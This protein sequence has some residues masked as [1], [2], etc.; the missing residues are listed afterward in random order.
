MKKELQF[1]EIIS[2]PCVQHRA[3]KRKRKIQPWEIIVPMMF[4]TAVIIM[5]GVIGG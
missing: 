3:T 2:R 1:T 4:I 5:I